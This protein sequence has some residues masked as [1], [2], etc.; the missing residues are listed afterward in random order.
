MKL[1]TTTFLSGALL[2][3][4]CTF[5]D[6]QVGEAVGGIAG[7][8]IGSQ[9]GGGSGQIVA[10]IGGALLGAWLGNKVAAGMNSQDKLYYE[11][12][13]NQAQAAPIG[14]TIAWNN[15]QTGASGTV[16]PTREGETY[17]GQYCREFQQTITIDG[18]AERAYGVACRQPDGS[19]KI[20]D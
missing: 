14:Q 2:L 18:R 11:A 4:A 9:F 6:E 3:S 20:V 7:G 1:M 5:T 13:A 15:P 17:G 12:A 8:F 16:T 19:W 10:S